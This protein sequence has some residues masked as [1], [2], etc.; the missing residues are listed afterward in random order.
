MKL[1]VKKCRDGSSIGKGEYQKL[2]MI[3]AWSS[4]SLTKDIWL[5]F[6]DRF[7]HELSPL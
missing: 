7:K 3:F 1:E 4:M 5:I 6:L 2:S